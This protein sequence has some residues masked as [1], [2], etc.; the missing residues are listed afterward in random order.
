MFLYKKNGEQIE[1]YDLQQD[2]NKTI[3]YKKEQISSEF[4]PEGKIFKAITNYKNALENSGET[5]MYRS[6][7]Q[8]RNDI[9]GEKIFSTLQQVESSLDMQ[10]LLTNYYTNALG[11]T[12]V[13]QIVDYDYELRKLVPLKYL[14][15]TRAWYIK[16]ENKGEYCM[17]DI[18]EINQALFYLYLLEQEE[19]YKLTDKDISEQL[20]LYNIKHHQNIN[21]AKLHKMYD[22]KLLPGVFDNVMQ[23]VETTDKILRKIK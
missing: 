5:I 2:I 18:I 6:I 15:L 17:P 4:G 3:N 16:T 23:K 14:L 20:A 9:I 11:Y 1:V 19:F 13:K 12:D 10:K 8:N 21:I 7:E 22:V